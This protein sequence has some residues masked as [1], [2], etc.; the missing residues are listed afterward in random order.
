MFTNKPKC[1]D[2]C[3]FFWKKFLIL[4]GYEHFLL[5]N[6]KKQSPK[7]FNYLVINELQTVTSRSVLPSCYSNKNP[8]LIKIS[9]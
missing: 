5:K 4:L 3:S 6:H 8:T 1:Q 7:I 9:I 2:F